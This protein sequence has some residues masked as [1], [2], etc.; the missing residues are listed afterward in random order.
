ML[1]AAWL[2]IAR[3]TLVRHDA[4]RSRQPSAARAAGVR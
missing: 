4:Q 1:G 3:L 2:S